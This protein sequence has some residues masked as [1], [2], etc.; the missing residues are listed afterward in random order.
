[1]RIIP[2]SSGK[3]GVGKSTF[4]IN[5]A[6]ALSRHAKTI[7]VDLDLGTSSV[8]NGIDTPVD[9]DLYHFFKKKTPLGEC[10]TTL[11]P[12]LD[13]EGRYKNF[14][15]IA[16]PRHL[17]EEITNFDKARKDLLI[18]AINGLNVPYVVLDLKAGLDSHVI[19]FL[20]Y[21]NSG[22]LVFTPHLPA[23]TLAASDIVKAILFRK[24]RAIFAKGSP[25]YQELKGV[26][27]KLVNG[28]I[29]QAE[30]VYDDSIQ[31]L[32][33]LVVELRARVGDHA[34]VARVASTLDFFRVHFVLNMF[35]GVKQS[36][37]TAIKPFVANLVENVSAH[38][39]IQNLGWVVS[40]EAFTKAAVRRVP[41]LLADEAA[42]DDTALKLR[43]LA[44]QYGSTKS[45]PPK[46]MAAKFNGKPDP[47]RY[48]E[49]QFDT[50]KKMHADM[51]KASY[52]ENFEYVA[53]RSLH[54]MSSRRVGDFGD[55]RI[56]KSSEFSRVLMSNEG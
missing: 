46:D 45:A 36:Y 34:A 6:L 38:L 17:I 8:R 55:D 18:K 16:A 31:N 50:L 41:A 14:G 25:V 42:T 11:A 9:K 21:S 15:F 4:A 44:A 52:K 37:E 54:L 30:D 2:I 48:L 19:D 10:V 12:R 47:T 39:S 22:I 13:P 49:A 56:F 35:N 33:S 5:Y 24:L 26:T 43:Q 29:D 7:L 3:G 20:P 40:D 51:K 1:M 53:Y 23:A 32:D 28:L 27:P